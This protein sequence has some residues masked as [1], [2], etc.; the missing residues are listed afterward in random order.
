MQRCRLPICMIRWTMNFTNTNPFVIV[1]ISLTL[2]GQATFSQNFKSSSSITS[3]PF[4]VFTRHVFGGHEFTGSLTLMWGLV[5]GFYRMGLLPAWFNYMLLCPVT[6]RSFVRFETHFGH[7][8]RGLV[9]HGIWYYWGC[10]LISNL[11]LSLTLNSSLIFY[12]II[13]GPF[14][15]DHCW[16]GVRESSI[17]KFGFAKEPWWLSVFWMYLMATLSFILQYCAFCTLLENLKELWGHERPWVCLCWRNLRSSGD[18]KYFTQFEITSAMSWVK[19]ILILKV[20]A[21]FPGKPKNKALW[22]HLRT[23]P[24]WL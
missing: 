21:P 6:A 5:V 8:F 9:W 12:W 17:T 11:M 22:R 18:F 14:C 24:C 16:S 1:T 19:I 10:S 15:W 20:Y 13:M 4:S 3:G 7:E 23:T 2:Q